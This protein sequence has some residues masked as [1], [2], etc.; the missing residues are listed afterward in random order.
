MVKMDKKQIK[1]YIKWLIIIIVGIVFIN[2]CMITKH[3]DKIEAIDD[4]QTISAYTKIA[5]TRTGNDYYY[6]KYE[7]IPEQLLNIWFQR[8]RFWPNKNDDSIYITGFLFANEPHDNLYVKEIGY[9]L[10]G[11]N[12]VL[13]INNTINYLSK[14]FELL[15]AKD[16]ESLI[17][18]GKNMYVAF[19]SFNWFGMKLDFS[20]KRFGQQHEIELTKIYSFDNKQFYEEKMKY[21]ITCGGKKFDIMRPYK[22]IKGFFMM[23]WA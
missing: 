5:Y 2:T 14:E 10:N 8:H 4:S 1:K 7:I 21:R 19:V 9:N 20:P 15:L 16:D 18:D 12:Y 3:P 11:K 17:I 6:T 13:I 22:S 23:L